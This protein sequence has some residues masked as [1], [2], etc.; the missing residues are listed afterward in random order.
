MYVKEVKT[1]GKWIQRKEAWCDHL[2]KMRVVTEKEF[3]DYMQN[4]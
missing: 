2:S 1:K 4:K 3:R